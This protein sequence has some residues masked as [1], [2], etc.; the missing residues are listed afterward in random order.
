MKKTVLTAESESVIL[1]KILSY[2]A[3]RKY[4][5]SVEVELQI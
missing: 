2:F 4:T 1:H 5:K 3:K